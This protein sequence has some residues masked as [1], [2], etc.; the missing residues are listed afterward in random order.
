M[1]LCEQFFLIIVPILRRKR[2]ENKI[3]TTNEHEKIKRTAYKFVR[4]NEQCAGKL[5]LSKEK[6]WWR[7]GGVIYYITLMLKRIKIINI[8]TRCLITP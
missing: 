8:S 2:N 4:I 5:L 7:N 1:L 3:K 6:G